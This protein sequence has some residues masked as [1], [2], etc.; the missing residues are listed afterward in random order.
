[1]YH[2]RRKRTRCHFTPQD[3]RTP[4]S[5]RRYGSTASHGLTIFNQYPD[6]KIYAIQRQAMHY[7]I[8]CFD[9]V[10]VRYRACHFNDNHLRYYKVFWRKGRY[11]NG[12][13]RCPY[14]HH[15]VYPRLLF[16]RQW[17]DSRIHCRNRVAAGIAEPVF[18]RL[19]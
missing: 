12:S 1:M 2:Q 11:K 17:P 13:H 7:G 4:P 15:S 19:G 16:V 10:L 18:N 5:G 3:R 9:S 8:D 6:D 14:R